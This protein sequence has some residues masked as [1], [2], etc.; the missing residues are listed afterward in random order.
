MLIKENFNTVHLLN[1]SIAQTLKQLHP[2][3]LILYNKTLCT[4]GE[5]TKIN[6]LII[7]FDLN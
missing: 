7:S 2:Q 6:Y 5:N 3:N 1:T 4:T